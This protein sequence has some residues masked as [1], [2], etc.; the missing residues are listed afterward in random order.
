MRI[1]I[2]TDGYLPEVTG[3]ATSV[4]ATVNELESRGHSVVIVAP[5]YPKFTDTCRYIEDR[6]VPVQDAAQR[7]SE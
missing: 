7:L 1:G 2:F 5:R 3:V 4:D 6:E